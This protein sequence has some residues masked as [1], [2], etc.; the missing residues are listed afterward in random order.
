MTGYRLYLGG[1][2]VG[3]SPST[4][5]VFSGLACGTSYTLGVAAVDGAGNVSGT[6]TISATTAVCSASGGGNFSGTF[7]C[8]GSAPNCTDTPAACTQ[9]I[10]SGIASA[11]SAAAAGSVICLRPAVIR[12]PLS[13]RYQRVRTWSCVLLMV[14]R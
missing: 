1:S 9:T 11:V 2:Q 6:A 3:T 4:S 8:Y 14:R 7:D 12:Q 5:Y 10:S 13:P